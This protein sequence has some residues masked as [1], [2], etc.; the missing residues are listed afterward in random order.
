MIVQFLS[1][2]MTQDQTQTLLLLLSGAPLMEMSHYV[3]GSD[4]LRI[5]FMQR[6]LI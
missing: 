2:L 1:S 4:G 3:E 6:N 5:L